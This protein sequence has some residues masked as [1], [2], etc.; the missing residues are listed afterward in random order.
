MLEAQ[1]EVPRLP[2]LLLRLRRLQAVPGPLGAAAGPRRVAGHPEH[3]FAQPLGRAADRAQ[4]HPLGPRVR[5]G[6]RVNAGLEINREGEEER[7]RAISAAAELSFCA[8][9]AGSTRQRF[10]IGPRIDGKTEPRLGRTKPEP[11]SVG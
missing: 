5:A 2:L 4:L 7:E 8:A 10:P 6:C 9:A 11:F 3:E 1:V